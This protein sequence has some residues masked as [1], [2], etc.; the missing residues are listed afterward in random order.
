[1]PISR[2]LVIALVTAVVVA[3][4]CS[5]PPAKPTV[6]DWFDVTRRAIAEDPPTTDVRQIDPSA[7]CELLDEL[8]QG[9]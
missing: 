1:M 9:R 3:V 6:E 4:G 2:P 7:P 8:D 5:S